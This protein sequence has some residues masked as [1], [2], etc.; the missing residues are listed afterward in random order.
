[1]TPDV[2]TNRSAPRSSVVPVL[3][4]ADVTQATAWLC[5][6]FGSIADVDP[7]SWGGT[8]VNLDAG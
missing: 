7:A 5:N 8:P 3:A 4:Y 2:V 6:A 1:M